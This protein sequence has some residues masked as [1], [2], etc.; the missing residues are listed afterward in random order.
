M[1][2]LWARKALLEQEMFRLMCQGW[3]EM[4]RVQRGEEETG[5]VG[6]QRA[7]QARREEHASFDIPLI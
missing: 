4:S 1:P 3:V 2:G 7:E 6:E 5:P